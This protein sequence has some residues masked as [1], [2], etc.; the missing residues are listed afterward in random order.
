MCQQSPPGSL[1]SALADHLRDERFAIVTS[2]RGL[3]LGVRDAM[4]Q[5]FGS[6]DLD[7]ADPGAAFQGNG[8]VDAA[9]PLRRLVAAGCSR[10]HHC[11]VYYE[12][13]GGSQTRHVALFLWTPESTR[14]EWGGIA[15]GG[16][17]TIDDVRAAALSGR[18]TAP[19]GPW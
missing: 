15:P 1:P 10:D 17:G 13:G 12:R 5:L 9:L 18:I 19:A 2:V 7:I 4:Q 8:H 14:F 6:S 11:L 16:L 3:P